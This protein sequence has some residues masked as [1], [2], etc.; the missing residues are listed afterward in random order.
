MVKI[1]V[2]GLRLVNG[3]RGSWRGPTGPRFVQRSAVQVDTIVRLFRFQFDMRRPVN[4]VDDVFLFHS[5]R[6]QTR[7][8]E[9]MLLLF[10]Y[11]LLLLLLLL[12]VSVRIDQAVPLVVVVIGHIVVTNLFAFL[13][14]DVIIGCRVVFWPCRVVDQDDGWIGGC[15]PGRL[16][17]MPII[18]GGIYH[19]ALALD[20][21]LKVSQLFGLAGGAW[22]GRT[23]VA[24]LLTEG[25]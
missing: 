11:V 12:M 23:G 10:L 13:R 16:V 7:R 9:K 3:L 17:A 22:R 25:R 19:G 15:G 6:V 1:G 14:T 2:A 18:D 5:G 4:A 21:E 20:L 8:A 24:A